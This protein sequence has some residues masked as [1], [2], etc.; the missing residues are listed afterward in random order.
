MAKPGDRVFITG[1]EG[2]IGSYLAELLIDMG[3]DVHGTVYQDTGNIGHLEGTLNVYD[4]NILDKEKLQSI[5]ENVRPAYVFHLAAQSL[6]PESW[7]DPERTFKINVLGTVC[8]FESIRR[9]RLDPVIEVACSSDEYEYI[10]DG[11]SPIQESGALCPSS[12]YG[13]SKLAEDMLSHVYWQAYGM[14]IIRVLPFSIIGPRKLSDACSDFAGGIAE[15]EAG[16]SAKLRVG[17]L[18]AVRDF[19]DVRDVVRAMW[20]IADKGVAGQA[21]NI[22][23]GNGRKLEDILARLTSLSSRHIDLVIDPKRM[24]SL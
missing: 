1:C 2:F 15:I 4:C 5:F 11:G 3:F 22:C 13:V 14:K 21:Y 20:L 19:V 12:P 24:R 9:A 8:L 10:D 18:D 6:I 17:N 23:S 16:K 7:A